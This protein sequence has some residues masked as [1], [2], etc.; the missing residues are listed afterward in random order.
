MRVLRDE[1]LL[2]LRLLQGWHHTAKQRSEENKQ[3]NV[4]TKKHKWNFGI[5]KFSER[6]QTISHFDLFKLLIKTSKKDEDK[7][8]P[9]HFVSFD[10]W[11]QTRRHNGLGSGDVL[12]AAFHR[13]V[14]RDLS[15]TVFVLNYCQLN[16]NLWAFNEM[17][18]QSK[19][20]DNHWRIFVI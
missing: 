20:R 18:K 3:S 13:W 7:Y 8:L 17:N 15:R 9:A 12:L 5:K 11:Q 10:R 2:I 6:N 4:K 14:A 16:C 19:R 1:H